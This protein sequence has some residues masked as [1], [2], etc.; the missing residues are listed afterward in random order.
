MDER[1]WLRL[2][3]ILDAIRQ[4]ELVFG[5]LEFSSFVE[6]RVKRAACERFLEI[7]SEASRHIPE[8][9]KEKYPDIPWR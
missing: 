6:D 9:W 3:D 2:S 8:V 5:Q 7:V 4:L 1:L